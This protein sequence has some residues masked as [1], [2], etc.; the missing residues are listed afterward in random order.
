MTPAFD[1]ILPFVP[2]FLLVFF[3]LTGLFLFAPVFGSNVIPRRV[4]AL[5][6]LVL[7]FCIFP[8]V[9]PH[10]PIVLAMPAF[11]VTVGTELL[12]GLVIGYGASLPLI[13]MQIGGQLI[14]QQLGLGLAQVFNPDF[15]EETEVLSQ[16]LFLVALVVFLLLNGEQMLITAL[17][18]SF[19]DV[20][21]GGMI[22]QGHILNFVLGLLQAMFELGLRVAA[23][24]LCM[25]FLE[26][27]A[28][29]FVARTVPQLNILTL[30]FP[31]RIMAGFLLMVGASCLLFPS[32]SEALRQM[33]IQLTQ[34]F[35]L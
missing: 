11:A 5:L 1:A 27:V 18:H 17:A 34:L 23:P 2:A 7:T 10:T 32:I 24:L 16:F 8:I 29:G 25:I 9:A 21:I 22:P 20:P 33:F 31:L 28:M 14:G 19:R 15:N 30:G 3:R 6:A 35:T 13:A 12:I 4:K 26:T